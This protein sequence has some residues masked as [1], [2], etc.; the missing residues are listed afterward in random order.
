[1]DQN[2]PSAVEAQEPVARR[3]GR[4]KREEVTETKRRRRKDG[5]TEKLAIPQDVIDKHPDME[6]RWGRDDDARLYQLTKSD[7]WDNVPGVDPIHGGSKKNGSAMQLHLL[8]KPKEFMA[9]DRAK[10]LDALRETEQSKLTLPDLKTA[11]QAGGSQYAV[12]GNKL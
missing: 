3:P 6:F 1:M 12:D 4:P 11:T 8:M 5:T 10:K 2:N 9:E 7:D